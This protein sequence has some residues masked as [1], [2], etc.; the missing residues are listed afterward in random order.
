MTIAELPGNL[1]MET[2][3]VTAKNAAAFPEIADEAVTAE[4]EAAQGAVE[5]ESPSVRE[6]FLARMDEAGSA[7]AFLWKLNEEK[8]KALIEEE[9]E[10]LKEQHGLYK[11]PP[12]Q[13]QERMEAVEAVINGVEAFV[14]KLLE[15][16]REKGEWERTG[17]V[18][19]GKS[20]PLSTLLKL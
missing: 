16:L 3:A 11:E 5:A 1:R 17:S 12:L 8:I 4:S 14:K 18:F 13:G 6:E 7:A 10:R 2:A 19:V 15:E 9:R 20:S